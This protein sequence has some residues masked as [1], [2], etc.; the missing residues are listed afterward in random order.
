LIDAISDYAIYMLDQNRVV[1]SGNNG[2]QRLQGYKPPEVLGQ[3]FARFYTDEDRSA[4]KP[5][6][7]LLTAAT[8][9]R[10]ESEGWRVRKDGSRS[11]AH[12]VLDRIPAPTGAL[13]GFDTITR[14]RPKRRGVEQ[15]LRRSEEDLRLLLKSLTDYAI[16]RRDPIPAG[17]GSPSPSAWPTWRMVEQATVG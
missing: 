7:P 1:I 4:D 15:A 11:C 9:G 13:I 12:A 6:R 14:E 3:N 8:E 2:A 17:L 5:N 10:H 16:Y